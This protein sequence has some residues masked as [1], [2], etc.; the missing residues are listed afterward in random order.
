MGEQTRLTHA[1]PILVRSTR[2]ARGVVCVRAEA[3]RAGLARKAICPHGGTGARGAKQAV[4]AVR[5]RLPGRTRVLLTSRKFIDEHRYA[6]SGDKR[7]K[8]R[9]EDLEENKI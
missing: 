2:L 4:L 1:H 6:S 7:A 3:H 9:V 8:R 5:A